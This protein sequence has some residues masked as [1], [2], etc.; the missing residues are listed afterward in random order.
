[1]SCVSGPVCQGPV[2]KCNNSRGLGC[3]GVMIAWAWSPGR[4]QGVDFTG[5]YDEVADGGLLLGGGI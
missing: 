1:V 2:C 5:D 4:A 3:V